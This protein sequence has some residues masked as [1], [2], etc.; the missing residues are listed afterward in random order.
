MAGIAPRGMGGAS[1][2][3]VVARVVR[4]LEGHLVFL[5]GPPGGCG[6]RHPTARWQFPSPSWIRARVARLRAW[7]APIEIDGRLSRCAQAYGAPS[8]RRLERCGRVR[9]NVMNCASASGAGALFVSATLVSA[10]RGAI[11]GSETRPSTLIPVTGC[12]ST[13]RRWA[14]RWPH[15]KGANRAGLGSA[16]LWRAC[17]RGWHSIGKR[18]PELRSRPGVGFVCEPLAPIGKPPPKPLSP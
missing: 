10:N 14:K 8:C 9:A 13:A 2:A 3:G 16:L 11:L 5:G 17:R 15:A 4:V 12:A 6:R 1:I 18:L 7:I